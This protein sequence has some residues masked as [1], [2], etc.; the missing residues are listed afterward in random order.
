MMTMERMTP[1]SIKVRALERA[2][3]G[4]APSLPIAAS[5]SSLAIHEW[6][7]SGPSYLHTH[8]CDDEAF[9][10]LEGTL[11]FRFAGGEANAHAGTTVFVPTGVAHTCRAAEGSRY[12]IV[13]TPKL[14]RLIARLLAMPVDEH[15]AKLH[16]TLAEFDTIISE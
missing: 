9:H 3:L 12:L 13:L 16:S 10:V 1:A 6:T 11:T 14:D 8:V 15:E 5:G 2:I 4:G 7:M